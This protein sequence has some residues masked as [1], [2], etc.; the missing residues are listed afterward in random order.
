MKAT[1]FLR[2]LLALSLP[3]QCANA[4]EAIALSPDGRML[5]SAGRGGAIE[6]WDRP[7]GQLLHVLKAPNGVVADNAA[8]E[9]SPDGQHLGYAA[10]KAACLWNVKTGEVEKT[11]S[12][13][14]GLI[15]QMSS[16]GATP[17]SAS[18]PA[19]GPGSK[20]TSSS[21]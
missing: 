15:S 3:V 2:V 8:L 7:S 12:L 16:H 19:S 6:I 1:L 21:G 20:T 9:F 5:A 11:W 18:S 17:I 10:G 4:V 14:P 13:S